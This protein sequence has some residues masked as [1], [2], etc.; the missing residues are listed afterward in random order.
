MR[1]AT[2][3]LA[4]IAGPA[5]TLAPTDRADRPTPVPSS[6]TPAAASP[7]S[8]SRTATFELE[9]GGLT[10][11]DL[12]VEL[13]ANP[14][15]DDLELV[16]SAVNATDAPIALTLPDGC[17]AEPVQ[18]EGLPAGYDPYQACARA[19]CDPS[20][21]STISVE[22][23]PRGE[24]PLARLAIVPR[25]ACQPAIAEDLYWV[26]GVLPSAAAPG[27]QVCPSTQIM[28]GIVGGKVSVR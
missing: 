5:C 15:G 7:G 14:A 24:V 18:L 20:A 8:S 10:I 26:S 6:T 23:P 11:C 22:V 27:R 28:L 12:S 21:A 2:L 17:G 9:W 1:L 3:T 16:A 13:A 19:A 4:L 25:S